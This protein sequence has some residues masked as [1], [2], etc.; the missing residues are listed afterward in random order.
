MKRVEFFERCNWI[1]FRGQFTRTRKYRRKF[2]APPFISSRSRAT[3]TRG[4]AKNSKFRP[5]VGQRS[6]HVYEPIL[7]NEQVGP[8]VTGR[9]VNAVY[10][11]CIN[12]LIKPTPPFEL[13]FVGEPGARQVVTERAPP[14]GRVRR[15]IRN[16]TR[17]NRVTGRFPTTFG[18]A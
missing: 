4:K 5:L 10:V 13:E 2:S 1:R 12:L 3:I 17:Y 14:F 15:N 18:R 9:R 8:E 16:R 7:L 11:S 6:R